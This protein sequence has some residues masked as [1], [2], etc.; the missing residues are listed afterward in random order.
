MH[1]YITNKSIRLLKKVNAKTNM[2]YENYIFYLKFDKV[3]SGLRLF[4]AEIKEFYTF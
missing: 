4:I 1:Q 3:I 2:K